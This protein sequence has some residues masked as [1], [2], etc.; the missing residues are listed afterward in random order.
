ALLAM[1]H[2][3]LAGLLLIPAAGLDAIDGSLA[4]IQNRVTRFGAFLDSTMD[5]LSEAVLFLGALVYY[6]SG[7]P[8]QAEIILVFVALV[9]SLMVSYTKARSEAVGVAIKG[10]LLT[11]FERMVVLIIGMVLHELTIA[12]WV[13]AILAH[14]TVLQRIWITWRNTRDLRNG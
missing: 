5:R 4:R 11:R 10:G 9:G 8:A 1:G 14:I 6:L 3:Q 13:L 2:V 12:L 7:S